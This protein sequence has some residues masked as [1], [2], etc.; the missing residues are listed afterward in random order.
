M[1]L[2]IEEEMKL[3]PP[4][5]EP[6][7]IAKVAEVE[8]G[9]RKEA[10]IKAIEEIVVEVHS[11]PYAGDDVSQNRMGNTYAVANGMYNKMVGKQ[12][13]A[14]AN[15]LPNGHPAKELLQSIG[16]IH[17]GVYKAVYKDNK[18]DWKGS[19]KKMHHVEAE[20]IGEALLA[21]MLMVGKAIKSAVKGK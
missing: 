19:D 16:A 12:F 14:Q 7:Y 6:S 11:V 10:K 3:F 2:T 1:N 18:L 13:I 5:K 9:I 17:E 8:K 15:A 4:E 20:S 21:S